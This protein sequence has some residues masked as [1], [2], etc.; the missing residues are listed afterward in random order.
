M[1]KG[2]IKDIGIE[3]E[4]AWK[5]ERSLEDGEFG[6]DNSIEFPYSIVDNYDDY[7]IGELRSPVLTLRNWRRWIRNNY[8]DKGNKTCGL[9]IHLTFKKHRYI[10]DSFA[11]NKFQKFFYRRI[12]ALNSRKLKN[13]RVFSTR[14]N[15]RCDYCL[16]IRDF[17]DIYKD[18]TAINFRALDDHGTLEI[19]ILP[20]FHSVDKAIVAI[21]EILNIFNTYKKKRSRVILKGKLC[22]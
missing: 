21:Q 18:R 22:V 6:E 2:I 17:K 16:P 5:N 15:G 11:T 13:N 19:R 10:F 1:G 8:P 14:I 20:Y 12:K 4:G 3:L 9:H 7:E